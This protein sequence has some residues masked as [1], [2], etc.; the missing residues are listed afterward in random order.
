[1]FVSKSLASLLGGKESWWP[2]C[3]V[4]PLA[5]SLGFLYHEFCTLRIS[6]DVLFGQNHGPMNQNMFYEYFMIRCMVNLL[7]GQIYDPHL[8]IWAHLHTR[9]KA[10]SG[11]AFRVHFSSTLSQGP[12][13]R[14][15]RR[16][17]ALRAEILRCAPKSRGTQQIRKFDLA[18]NWWRARF[19]L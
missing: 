7:V 3:L 5:K 1:M 9:L 13:S 11:L 2:F 15:V 12:K 19:A 6:S 14:V 10:S 8:Q 16:N 17:P 4:S 18:K